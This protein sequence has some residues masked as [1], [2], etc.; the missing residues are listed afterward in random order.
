[1]VRSGSI[2]APREAVVLS[3]RPARRSTDIQEDSLSMDERILLNLLHRGMSNKEI[4][5]ELGLAE[6]TIKSRFTRLY[7]RFGVNTRVQILSLA[8]RLN[9]IEEQTIRG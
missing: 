7:K 1:M 8:M 9:V 2:W 3:A 6:V 4:A 5:N